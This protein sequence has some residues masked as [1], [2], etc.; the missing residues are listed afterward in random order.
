MSTTSLYAFLSGY[1]GQMNDKQR[2][3]LLD[4]LGLTS[5]PD[6]L[7]DLWYKYLVSIGYSG[8][9]QDMFSL[10]LK[11]NGLDTGEGLPLNTVVSFGH[12]VI[13]N[14]QIVVSN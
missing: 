10:W 9:L 3:W 11:D 12:V 1:P 14:N 8:S 2:A 13:S 5:P 6:A 7:N 4:M